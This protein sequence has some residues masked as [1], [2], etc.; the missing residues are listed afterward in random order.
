MQSQ[1]RFLSILYVA[2]LAFLFALLIPGI[3]IAENRALLV[4][5]DRFLSLSDTTPSSERNVEEMA[6]AL[7]GGAM[8]M[9][10]LITRRYGISG[11]DELRGLIL[12]AFEAAQPGDVSYFYIST[13]G[14]WEPGEPGEAHTGDEGAGLTLRVDR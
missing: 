2:V 4:G 11:A 3:S 9:E 1:D 10:T 14:L 7:S 13:H 8:N 5:C 12:E 6:D